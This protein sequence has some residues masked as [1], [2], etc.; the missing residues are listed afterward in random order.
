[1]FIQWFG[2]ME[3]SRLSICENTRNRFNQPAFNLNL[4]LLDVK[5]ICFV[6][7]HHII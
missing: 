2:F 4:T 3:F 7:N 5:K 1:M 6:E